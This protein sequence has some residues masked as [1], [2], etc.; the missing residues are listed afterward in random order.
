MLLCKIVKGGRT[1]EIAF[2][3]LCA[4]VKLIIMYINKVKKIY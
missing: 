3:K 2:T 4:N 1:G